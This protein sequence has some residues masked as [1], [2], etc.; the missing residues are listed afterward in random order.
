[1]NT[2][3]RGTIP[4]EPD[5]KMLIPHFAGQFIKTIKKTF[6]DTTQYVRTYQ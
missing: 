4:N 1:M 2:Q 5:Y 6:N 3:P